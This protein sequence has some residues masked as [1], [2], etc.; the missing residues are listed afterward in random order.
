MLSPTVSIIRVELFAMLIMF[1]R[2]SEHATN[3]HPGILFTAWLGVMQE[4]GNI[5]SLKLPVNFLLDLKSLG[6]S[7]STTPLLITFSY[8]QCSTELRC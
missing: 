2:F 3:K 7:T 6:N 1:N 8:R 5:Q 4:T